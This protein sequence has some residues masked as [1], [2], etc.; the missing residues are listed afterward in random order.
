MS[1]LRR[2]GAV[3][4]V[5][6]KCVSSGGTTVLVT[7]VDPLKE[8][9]MHGRVVSRTSTQLRIS[10]QQLFDVEDQPWRFAES[11]LTLEC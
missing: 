9:P 2:L 5:I 11:Y 3:I 4:G 7:R 6:D 10:F 8:R 1:I